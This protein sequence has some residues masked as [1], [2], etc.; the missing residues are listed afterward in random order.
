MEIAYI[1]KIKPEAVAEVLHWV[2][3]PDTSQLQELQNIKI[4]LG[5][6][7]YLVYLNDRE[8]IKLIN[9]LGGKC[10]ND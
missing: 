7:Y 1:I 4:A 2:R 8:S 9:A 3:N 10:I 6:D 5:E